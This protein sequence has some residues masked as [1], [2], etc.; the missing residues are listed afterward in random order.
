[1]TTIELIDVQLLG[2]E[3]LRPVLADIVYNNDGPVSTTRNEAIDYA[4]DA[5][6]DLRNLESSLRQ[7]KNALR[8]EANKQ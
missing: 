1:M 6:Q 3:L 7:L 2:L 4:Y 8:A 5:R